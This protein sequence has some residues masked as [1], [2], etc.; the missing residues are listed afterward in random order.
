MR[1]IQLIL[2]FTWMIQS[3]ELLSA[4]LTANNKIL[5][6]PGPYDPYIGLLRFDKKGL[7]KTMI[8]INGIYQ[9][10]FRVS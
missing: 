5:G 2:S 10:N 1:R 6:Y 9:T 8:V 4:R 7:N 3:E